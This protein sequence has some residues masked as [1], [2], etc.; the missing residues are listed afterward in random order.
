MIGSLNNT[1]VLLNHCD[2]DS[3]GDTVEFDQLYLYNVHLYTYCLHNQKDICF[4]MIKKIF[5]SF[6]SI[7]RYQAFNKNHY[8]KGFWLMLVFSL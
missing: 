5:Y 4:L 6:D 8:E 7:D 2:T 1:R 3:Y